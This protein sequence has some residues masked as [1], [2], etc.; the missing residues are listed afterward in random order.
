M[1]FN[2]IKLN[3]QGDIRKIAVGPNYKDAMA[4]T[5]GQNIVGGTQVIERI[6]RNEQTGSIELYVK[7]KNGESTIYKEF[8]STV[9]ISIEYNLNF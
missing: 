9:P 8:T 1:L 6:K 5:V 7:N 4:Y 2:L 3:I